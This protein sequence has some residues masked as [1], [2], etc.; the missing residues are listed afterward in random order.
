[1]TNIFNETTPFLLCYF[2][3]KMLR[4]GEVYINFTFDDGDAARLHRY[5]GPF[6]LARR[7]DGLDMNGKGAS[8]WTSREAVMNRA[9]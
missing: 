1:M 8:I 2:C 9:N 7:T 6:A 4:P 3:H 5:C